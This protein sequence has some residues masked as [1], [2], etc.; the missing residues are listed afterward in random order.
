M[1]D[2]MTDV[3]KAIASLRNGGVVLLPTDTV[4]GLAVLPS[5][6]DAVDKL[7]RL[8]QRPRARSLPVMVADQGQIVQLG[9]KLNDRITRLLA[10]DLVPGALTIVGELDKS[11]APAWLSDRDEVAVRIPDNAVLLT[12]LTRVGPLLV[13]SANL[14]GA[15]TA[16]NAADV[17]AQ[18]NGAPDFVVEGAVSSDVPSTLVNCRHDPVTIERQ[19]A[20]PR[21][22]ITQLVD[23]QHD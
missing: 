17:L 6:G 15:P 11:V 21:A 13:T 9:M 12:L 3:E 1:T 19:G 8:K 20:I 16:T 10:S 18:L 22:N 2:D 14:H 7:Y 23:V 5:D 4:Y